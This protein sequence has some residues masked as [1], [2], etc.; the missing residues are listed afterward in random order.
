MRRWPLRIPSPLQSDFQ[1]FSD[2]G[3]F[4]IFI[5]LFQEFS[6][7]QITIHYKLKLKKH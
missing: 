2:S 3:F 5:A 7:K 6:M 4:F 1:F